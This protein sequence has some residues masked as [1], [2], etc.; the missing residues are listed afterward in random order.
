MYIHM[1]L[2]GNNAAVYPCHTYASENQHKTPFSG[3]FTHKTWKSD[4]KKPIVYYY[5]YVRGRNTT[6]EGMIEESCK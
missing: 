6:G 3:N 1:V 2:K 4:R 5:F